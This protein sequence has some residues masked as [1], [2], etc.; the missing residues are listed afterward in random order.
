MNSNVTDKGTTTQR[1]TLSELLGQLANNSADVV[2]D[3]IEL[4]IQ[5]IREKATAGR[6]GVVTVVTGAAIG[7]AAFLSLCAALII[8]LS[9]YMAPA[10]AALVTG[11]TLALIGSVIAFIGYRQLKKSIRNP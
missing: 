9:A 7:F 1:D 2:H 5:G 4:V 3:E 11:A 10:M 6:S 8:G